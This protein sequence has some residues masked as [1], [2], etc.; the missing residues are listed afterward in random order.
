[1]SIAV[2]AL[3]RVAK[4]LN[5]DCAQAVVGFNFKTVG[6]VP[7][8]E[9]YVVCEEYEDTLRAAWEE[10]QV[11]AAQRAKERREQRIYGN[12]RKLIRG[13]MIKQRLAKKYEM[14]GEVEDD[15]PKPSTSSK[16]GRQK[17]K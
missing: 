1:M 12:W 10:E 4:K 8:F 16:R 13:M 14:N 15:E 3:N 11:L 2:P 9:G 5:I 17:K 7:A 6:A